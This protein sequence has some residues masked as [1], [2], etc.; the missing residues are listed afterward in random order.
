MNA[1]YRSEAEIYQV[2]KQSDE[3]IAKARDLQ[4]KIATL[5]VDPSFLDKEGQ[6]KYEG[7]LEKFELLNFRI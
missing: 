3:K 2:Q 1:S 6:K 7:V 5:K 4:Q